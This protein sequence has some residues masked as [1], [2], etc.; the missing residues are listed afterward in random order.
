MSR[1]AALW[2][3]LLLALMAWPVSAQEERNP[4]AELARDGNVITGKLSR[5]GKTFVVV[6]GEKI[7]LCEKAEI[8]D[9]EENP[10][11]LS[12]LCATEVVKV[13]LDNDCALEVQAIQ[14]RR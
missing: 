8:L 6:A 7:R 3:G 9:P 4:L 13:T 10:I 12:G 5:Y 2:A 1:Y 14:L 11:T